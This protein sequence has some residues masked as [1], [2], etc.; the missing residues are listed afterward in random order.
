MVDR[1]APAKRIE[2]LPP[3]L[4]LLLRRIGVVEEMPVTKL[5]DF[6][7]RHNEDNLPME[8]LISMFCA[9][10]FAQAATLVG[11]AAAN[12][13]Q[14]QATI[15]DVMG[16]LKMNTRRYELAVLCRNEERISAK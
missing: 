13:G 6:L 2:P 1:S 15:K 12:H 8:Q 7:A 14:G 3:N 9:N 11:H 4:L 10:Y 16:S 5:L